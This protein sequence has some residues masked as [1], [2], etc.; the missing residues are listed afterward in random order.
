[1]GPVDTIGRVALAVVVLAFAGMVL[2]NAGGVGDVVNNLI[3]GFGSVL[4]G[5]SGQAH[6]D[7]RQSSLFGQH[8]KAKWSLVP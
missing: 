3:N 1:M 5:A 7:P 2:S 4:T 8:G 6:L